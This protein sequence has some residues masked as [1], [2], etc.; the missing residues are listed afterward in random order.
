MKIFNMPE[1]ALGTVQFGM[2]YGITNQLGKTQKNE[3]KNILEYAWKNGI[4]TLDTA[5]SYG[6]S[7]EV[8]GEVIDIDNDWKIITKIPDIKSNSIGIKHINQMLD[9]FKNSLSKLKKE[10]IY[11]LLLHN[12]SNIFLPGGEKIFEA[13]QQL[14]KDGFIKKIGVSLYDQEQINYLLSNYSV[15]LVQIPINILDQRLI[16]GGELKKLKKQEVEIHARS[17][18]LQ[19]LLLSPQETLPLSFKPLLEKIK[20]FHQEAN[21]RNISAIQLSLGFVKSIKEI[22]KVVLGINTLE[23]L[24]EVVNLENINFDITEFSHLKVDD[25]TLLNPSNWKV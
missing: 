12:C 14:K 6:N 2:H 18:F 17:V 22:D 16:D 13:M 24:Y 3:T 5:S 1:I 25:K 10:S 9:S 4:N 19:G 11:G 7:E 21:R 23:H 8:L 20:A 15:D